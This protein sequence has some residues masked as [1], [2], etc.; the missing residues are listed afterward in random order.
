M[1]IQ[2]CLDC[3]KPLDKDLKCPNCGKIYSRGKIEGTQIFPN[4]FEETSPSVNQTTAD[5]RTSGNNGTGR[6]E[7]TAF[8]QS[9][10][11]AWM[12]QNMHHGNG[13]GA[14]HG[15]GPGANE[16]HTPDTV[17]NPEKATVEEVTSVSNPTEKEK[18]SVYS[19]MAIVLSIIIVI[20][21]IVL[22]VIYKNKSTRTSAAASGYYLAETNVLV[23]AGIE[24]VGFFDQM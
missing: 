24:G 18:I 17:S 5:N 21:L 16:S 8:D 11:D 13:P 3:G 12:E 2:F 9:A 20:Q 4:M 14:N 6:K 19:I 15:N 23:E 1:N 10:W 22:F 7:S